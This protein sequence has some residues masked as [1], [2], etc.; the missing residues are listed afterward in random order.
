MPM[1]MVGL[2]VDC[3]LCSFQVVEDLALGQAVR[4]AVG[5]AVRQA[6]RQA[7]GKAV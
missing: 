4:Q 5:Q 3:T 2:K 7:V 1:V 6:V